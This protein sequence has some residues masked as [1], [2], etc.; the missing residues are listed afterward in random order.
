M[1]NCMYISKIAAQGSSTVA[2]TTTAGIMAPLMGALG[3]DS[4]V[5]SVLCV[6]AIGA[7]AMTVSHANHTRRK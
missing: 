1:G 6:M 4:T 7:D 2:I 3:M 5:M